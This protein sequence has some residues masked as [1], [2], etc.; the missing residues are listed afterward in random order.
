MDPQETNKYMELQVDPG[1][2]TI[3]INTSHK[4]KLIT[5]R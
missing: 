3:R 5:E 1:T 2:S 4:H